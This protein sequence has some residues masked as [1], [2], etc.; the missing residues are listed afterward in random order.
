[1]LRI[2]TKVFVFVWVLVVP[3]CVSWAQLPNISFELITIREGLPSNT[4]LCATKDRQGFMWFGTRHCPTRYDGTTFRHFEDFQTELV[5]G[6][7]ADSSNSIWVAT[8]LSGICK[9]DALTRQ[10]KPVPLATTKEHKQT[11]AFFI[12]SYGQG[13]YSDMSGVNR[14]HLK[15]HQSVHYAFRQTTY[16]WVKGSFLEDPHRTLWVVGS[17]NGLFRYDRTKDAFTCVLG[18]DAKDQHR[19]T[20]FVFSQGSTDQDGMLWLG[21]YGQGLLQYNPQSGEYKQFNI[22]NAPNTI[23]SVAAGIDENGRP[24]LWI[25]AEERLGIFR[26]DEGRFYWFP[27][28]L[29]NAYKVHYI[30]RD[31]TEGIVWV[32]TSEGILKYNPHSNLIQSIQIPPDIVRLPVTVTTFLADQTDSTGETFWLGLSHTG[33]LRW[34]RKTQ[35][36]TLVAYPPNT[37]APETRW[38]VQQADGT[39]WIGV[40][41]WSY[42]RPGLYVYSPSS[43]QFLQTPQSQQANRFFSVPFFMYGLMDPQS[44]L[45]IGNSDEGIRVLAPSGKEVT[46]WDSVSQYRQ[47]LANNNLVNDILMDHKGRMWLATY[48]GIYYADAIGQR[49]LNIDSANAAVQR[50]CPAVNSLYEDSQGNLWAARWGGITMTDSTG[51]LQLLLTTKD[52]SYDRENRGIVED[53]WGNIWIG[54]YEGVLRYNPATK[55]LLRFTAN[56]GLLNNNTLDHLYIQKGRELLIGQRNGINLL[57]INKLHNLVKPPAIEISSFK[58]HDR[59]YFTDFSK[60]IYLKRTDNAFRV[61]FGVLNYR[62]VQDNQYAYFLE[63]LDNGWTNSG[64]RHEVSY[65]NLAPGHYVLHLKAGD[66]LGNWNP[67]VRSLIIVV[68]PAYYETWLF[69]CLVIIACAS[70]LYG[71]YRYRINQLLS[72][73]RVRDQI[74]AD[75]HDEIGSSLSGISIMSTL[76][77]EKLQV[78]HPSAPFLQRIIEE[79]RLISTSLDDIVWSINPKNDDLANLIARM[80]RYASELFEAKGIAYT[81]RVPD[82]LQQIKLSMEKRRDFYLL[83]KEV[84]NNLIKHSDCKHAWIEIQ[85]IHPYLQLFVRDDGVGFDVQERTE[86]NGLQNLQKRSVK[87]HGKLTIETG[88]GQGTRVQLKFPV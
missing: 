57:L 60:P 47:L 29:S 2:Q 82:Q 43:G 49:F 33:M 81:I 14:V 13:W 7:A 76:A 11:S 77:Q 37:S 44:R 8:D 27:N 17:D 70:L 73:Q 31:A 25:G 52:Y 65:N 59:D 58:I 30:Y 67:D 64:N 10:M 85:F 35:T 41:Q 72:L 12:D 75:L 63:G 19:R 61:D 40:N 83:F 68:Q 4:V 36:F 16:V 80:T 46:P 71:F 38:M 87:L 24:I 74:S 9:I 84:T 53:A 23:S 3:L 62:K 55:Q 48:R 1:M 66:G 21:T 6:V 5:M 20:P 22:P 79:S 86:R 54:N 28:L 26:P 39:I 56:D 51:K 42:H 45:W 32:C 69:K 18:A 15:T 50:D 34:N 88:H 78:Q